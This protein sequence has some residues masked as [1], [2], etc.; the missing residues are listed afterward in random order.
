[1][2]NTQFNYWTVHIRAGHANNTTRHC[3]LSFFRSFFLPFVFFLSWVATEFC[4]GAIETMTETIPGENMCMV[5]SVASLLASLFIASDRAVRGRLRKALLR[6]APKVLPK[7]FFVRSFY[8]HPE[9]SD[10]CLTAHF[11][12]QGQGSWLVIP[13]RGRG[14]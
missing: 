12:S 5:A 4:G 9:C 14:R 11:E 2:A 7:T 1:V 10:L 13:R 3:K 8:S 6:A